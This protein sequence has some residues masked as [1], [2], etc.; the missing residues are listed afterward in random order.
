MPN[1]G[2]SNGPEIF[3]DET[4]VSLLTRK[5]TNGLSVSDDKGATW[6]PVADPIPVAIANLLTQDWHA[7][8]FA[9]ALS[10]VP[11]LTGWTPIPVTLIPGGAAS[12]TA[13]GGYAGGAKSSAGAAVLEYFSRGMIDLPK[14]G[15]WAACF[16]G[17]TGF[18]GVVTN[19][20]FGVGNLAG[21]NFIDFGS[22]TAQSATNWVVRNQAGAVTTG[23]LGDVNRH[24]FFL[25]ADGTN[26]T[27]CV[28]YVANVVVPQSANVL[29]DE[30]YAPFM[31]GDVGVMRLAR[32]GVAFV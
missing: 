11:Q 26:I 10:K 27:I 9:F 31:I 17:Q 12:I 19:T 7:Q 15:R 32:M 28:D 21:T 6:S 23:S 8:Q 20:C 16:D 3:A 22:F 30:M 4:G 29:T 13:D 2:Y 14:T 1:P 5:G 24:N 25:I 18:P